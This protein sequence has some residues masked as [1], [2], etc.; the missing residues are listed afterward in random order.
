MNCIHDNDKQIR[1]ELVTKEKRLYEFES[2]D[3]LSSSYPGLKQASDT[4]K[5]NKW[6]TEFETNSELRKFL[7]K[8]VHKIPKLLTCEAYYKKC[9]AYNA[10]KASMQSVF[11]VFL[12]T[13]LKKI[14]T[15]QQ[16]N[17]TLPIDA[18]NKLNDVIAEWNK[19]MKDLRVSE[20]QRDKTRQQCMQILLDA[21]DLIIR[22]YWAQKHGEEDGLT[23]RNHVVGG[24]ALHTT[25]HVNTALAVSCTVL[26]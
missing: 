11:R 4:W 2:V 21:H 23:V 12:T 13:G 6:M 25:L 26:R 22:S 3:S 24:N 10:L 8:N 9:I 1:D 18:F 14:A 5:Y 16:Q 19:G 7:T 17:L 15:G 20:G